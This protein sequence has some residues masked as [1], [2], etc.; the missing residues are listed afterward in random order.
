M[1]E[2]VH[3]DFSSPARFFGLQP[4]KRGQKEWCPAV[5]LFSL[6]LRFFLLAP[7]IH[8]LGGEFGLLS[9]GDLF[10]YSPK[11]ASSLEKAQPF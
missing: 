10:G 4:A 9:A 2:I 11:E 1:L 7:C 8:G 3:C 5:S 6:I